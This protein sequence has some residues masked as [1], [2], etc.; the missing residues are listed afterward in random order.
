MTDERWNPLD[1][2]KLDPDVDGLSECM[3][4]GI[5][6]LKVLAEAIYELDQAT[7]QLS[8][9]ECRNRRIYLCR[10]MI[11]RLYQVEAFLLNLCENLSE[12]EK[13]SMTFFQR[14]AYPDRDFAQAGPI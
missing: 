12:N 8:E 11:D 7:A 5:E 1:L 3:I 2:G 4:W 13:K 10:F 14:K 6:P 9:K